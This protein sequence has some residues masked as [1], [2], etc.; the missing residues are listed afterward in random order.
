MQTFE[1]FVGG[2][3]SEGITPEELRELNLY[4]E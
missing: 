4:V 3:I 2:L 1:S